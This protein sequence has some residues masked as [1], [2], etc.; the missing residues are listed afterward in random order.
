M[1]VWSSPL[2][3]VVQVESNKIYF[4]IFRH[5]YKFLRSLEVCTIFC[6]LNQLKNVLKSPHSTGPK[7]ARGYSAS[8]AACYT[9]S[10]RWATAWR[11]GPAAEAARELRARRPRCGVVTTRSPGVGRR[12]GTLADSPVAA[13]RWQGLELVHHG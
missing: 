2:R 13:S 1:G 6:E 4:V 10:A 12:G 3:R 8:S 9:W 5:S 11:P 7:S